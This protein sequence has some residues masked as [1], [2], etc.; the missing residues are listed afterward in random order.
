MLPL[1]THFYKIS[2]IFKERPCFKRAHSILNVRRQLKLFHPIKSAAMISG[3][4]TEPSLHANTI[5]IELLIHLIIAYGSGIQK[6]KFR[7]IKSWLNQKLGSTMFSKMEDPVE[8]VFIS[9]VTTKYGNV[10][11]FEGIWESSDFYLQRIY[12]IIQTLPDELNTRILI[13]EVHALLRLSEE[14]ASRRRLD[15]FIMGGGKKEGALKIPSWE[16]LKSLS[17]T[18][19]FSQNDLKQLGISP[20][21]LTPFIFNMNF[22]NQ[23]G[24]QVIGNSALERCP[25]VYYA[26]KWLVLLPTAISTAVRRYVLEWMSRQ[27]YNERFDQHI[28]MEYQDFLSKTSLLGSPIIKRKFLRTEKVASKMLLEIVKL[29]DEGRY[30]HIIVI[31]DSIDGYLS[32]GILS[33]DTNIEEL[34]NNLD[35]RIQKAKSYIRKKEG[36]KQGLTILVGCSY[37][38]PIAFQQPIETPDWWVEFLSAPDLQ[39]LSWESEGSP[40]ILWKLIAHNRFLNDKGISITNANGLLNLYGWWKETDYFM[41]PSK[42][43]FDGKTIHILIPTDCLASVRQNIRKRCDMHLLPHPTGKFISVRRNAADSYFPSETDKP[44]Y[45]C[46]EAAASGVLLGAWIG[47]KS[48]WWVEA[49]PGETQL[50]KKVIFMVWDAINNWLERAVPMLEQILGKK[51]NSILLIVLNFSESQQEQADPISEDMFR[52]C[53]SVTTDKITET[54]QIDFRDPFLGGFR[55]PKNYAERTLIRVIVDGIFKLAGK[56]STTE[57]LD[58]IVR[59]IIPNDD[60][61]YIHMFEAV[62]F[63]DYIQNYDRPKKLFIS[64][65]DEALSKLG[66]GWLVQER[67]E[68]GRFTSA[69]ESV[70]FLNLVVDAISKR[71]RL[72]LHKI[73]RKDLIEKALRHIEGVEAYRQLWEYSV[74]AVI[75]LRQDKVSSKAVAIQQIARCNT[76][77]IAL[78]LVIEMALSECPLEGGEMVGELDITPLMVDALCMFYLGGWSDAIKKGVMDPEVRIAPNGDVL[79]HVGFRDDVIDPLGQQFGLTNIDHASSKYD[80]HFEPFEPIPTVK[81]RF[82]DAFLEAFKAEFGLSVDALRGVREALENLAVEKKKCVFVASKEEIINYCNKSDLT[83]SETTRIVLDRFSLWPRKS[84]DTTPKGFKHKDWYPWRFGR[85]LSLIALPLVQL[86]EGENPR[87]MVSPGLVGVGIAYTLSKYYEAQVE[88]SECHTK[89]MRNWT[90]NETN[91]RGHAFAKQVFEVIQDL[92][93]KALLEN[94]VTAILNKDLNKDYG[95]MDVLAW[96]SGGDEVF[97]I[98]CKDLNFAKTPNE[99]AEQLN[100]F[101]GQILSNGKRDELLKHLDRCD[102]LRAH[103]KRVAQKVGLGNRDINI[104]TQS[105]ASAILSPCSLWQSGSRV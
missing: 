23:L 101:S 32:Y 103:A 13:S 76:N 82:P 27:G 78:R 75:A 9:N 60:A 86:E 29:V 65:S 58:T 92:G 70:L 67:V 93:Y 37:G 11:I 89:E 61:R 31:V 21:E 15:R 72:K 18:I 80:K 6:V 66:L 98:E 102:L 94:K 91:R 104:H 64:E 4:L 87:Y 39:A 50:S 56:V 46:I 95:D 88:I 3:L 34:S 35:L 45:A 44:L 8:D 25:I 83:T 68:G 54:I 85:R 10:R 84:W 77:N 81:G 17:R 105:S 47:E 74:R 48:V 1:Y 28:V 55:N 57:V 14:I 99:I 41:L 52:S 40:L 22:R 30:L 38:S 100:R 20:T 73:D 79:S 63:R 26:G 43:P 96:K 59:K 7:Q 90:D 51:S 5:R 2:G 42:I 69:A 36:F 19:T 16:I 53:L 33:P 71:M 49:K 24:N 97:A 12:N 62:N